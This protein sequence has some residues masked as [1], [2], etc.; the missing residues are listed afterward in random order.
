MPTTHAPHQLTES[1][2]TQILGRFVSQIGLP[3]RSINDCVNHEGCLRARHFSRAVMMQ[4]EGHPIPSQ[5][6]CTGVLKMSD[7]NRLLPSNSLTPTT[8]RGEPFRHTQA[9]FD[10]SGRRLK[11]HR[12]SQYQNAP[13]MPDVPRLS[14]RIIR[15]RSVPTSGSRSR[16]T[17]ARAAGTRAIGLLLAIRHPANRSGFAKPEYQ[18]RV[19]LPTGGTPEPQFRESKIE[20]QAVAFPPAAQLLRQS[21]RS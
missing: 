18:Q 13:A 12:R 17:L 1:S 11:T 4:S 7:T 10:Y 14:S 9:S 8:G 21:R 6:F 16:K 19:G 15:P 20:Y 5:L 2:W 3:K